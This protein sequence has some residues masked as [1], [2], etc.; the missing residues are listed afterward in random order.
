[1]NVSH[2]LLGR[3]SFSIPLN[4]NWRTLRLLYADYKHAQAIRI[5]FASWER[6]RKQRIVGTPYETE[7]GIDPLFWV[8][9]MS[10]MLLTKKLPK[11][12]RTREDNELSE[13][14]FES[15]M[16]AELDCNRT[17]KEFLEGIR[18]I[19]AITACGLLG[20]LGEPERF[21]KDNAGR[22]LR[23]LYHYA[24]LHVNAD[25]TAPKRRRGMTQAEAKALGVNELKTLLHLT[26]E[27]FRKCHNP[28]YTEAINA[29]K[30]RFK[31][32][33]PQKEGVKYSKGHADNHA[34]RLTSKLFLSDLWRYWQGVWRANGVLPEP[35]TQATYVSQS[36]LGFTPHGENVSHGTHGLPP[37]VSVVSQ[38]QLGRE[39]EETP[40]HAP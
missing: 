15:L 39:F 17:Y 37:H 33:H 28:R 1:M 16:K 22:G 25:G 11:D 18:G 35:E 34:L 31:Q 6:D 21:M 26:A 19:S 30:T 8:N 5:S 7:M 10:K 14:Y 23:S 32:K 13:K 29:F 27:N 40:N 2:S 36:E 20:I 9:G 12:N 24:G 38:L 4:H 3:E